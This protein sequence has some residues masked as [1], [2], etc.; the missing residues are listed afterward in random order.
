MLLRSIS[1]TD[2][3]SFHETTL[4]LRPLNVLIGPNASGKSNLIAAISLLKAA[5]DDLLRALYEGGGV[6]EWIGRRPTSSGV[7]K[8]TCEATL[9]ETE[10]PLR[11]S[12]AF[13]EPGLQITNEGLYSAGGPAENGSGRVF[14]ERNA[15]G[16]KIFR[17]QP[18]GSI[19]ESQISDPRS[20][21]AMYRDPHGLPVMTAFGKALSSIR[22]F[23]GFNTGPTAPSRMGIA[24]DAPK[25]F[26]QEDGSN[27]AL[28][29][30]EMDFHNRMGIVN[31]YLQR[32]WERAES[33][34][35]R[36]GGGI[37]QTYVKERGIDQPISA[38][39]LSDGT[40]KF[41]CLLAVLL[42]PE[43]PPLLCIDEPEAGFH[44]DGLSIVADLLKEASV[45]SQLIVTTHSEALVSALSDQPESVVVCE[46][47]AERGTEF[48]RLSSADLDNWLDRYR[49][50]EI[51]RKGE[52]GGNRW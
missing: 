51:W 18:E 45:R 6:R 32:F 46:R 33:A 47:Y 14:F 39:R 34:R 10:H 38:V 4:E 20:I 50:G 15:S 43:P 25:D 27:L 31:E 35:K 42:H 29:L 44:P 3:L 1:L 16:T 22:L 9:P 17:Q 49:L 8:L 2:L 21:L 12:L 28:I 5:P 52:I 23:R 26:L 7:A 13:T 30:D 40:L 19:M 37:A 36:L 48:T 24:S 41:L 11:Y